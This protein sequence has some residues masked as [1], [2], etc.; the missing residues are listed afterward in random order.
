MCG[1]GAV[2]DIIP[3]PCYIPLAA[4]GSVLGCFGVICFSGLS[5]FSA[6]RGKNYQFFKV[7]PGPSTGRRRLRLVHNFFVCPG[8]VVLVEIECNFLGVLRVFL[9]EFALLP[10]IIPRVAVIF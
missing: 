5:G 4:R 10:Y 3:E 8:L 9:K 2:P 6:P 7:N 1:G